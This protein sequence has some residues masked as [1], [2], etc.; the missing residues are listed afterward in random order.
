MA[1]LA[2]LASRFLPRANGKLL[3]S[4]EE[5]S[6][7]CVGRQCV[8]RPTGSEGEKEALVGVLLQKGLNSLPHPLV[9]LVDQLLSEVA[10]DL[11]RRDLLIRW[12]SDI[13]KVGD[14]EKEGEGEGGKGVEIVH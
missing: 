4:V 13:I 3:P 9:A 5:W 14:L 6:L 1:E 12:Q 10:V 8:I 11:L 7:Q 2:A